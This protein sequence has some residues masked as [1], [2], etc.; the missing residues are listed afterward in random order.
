MN[1]VT[2]TLGNGMSMLTEF[3]LRSE[4]LLI[5]LRL[6][7]VLRKWRMVHKQDKI[8]DKNNGVFFLI[9]LKA[10]SFLDYRFANNWKEPIIH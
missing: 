4:D 9:Y 8:A 3:Q 1:I 2:C 5:V 10:H 7:G 6:T